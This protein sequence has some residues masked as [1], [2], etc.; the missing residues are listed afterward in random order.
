M[1]E[2]IIDV[3]HASNSNFLYLPTKFPLSLAYSACFREELYRCGSG[4]DFADPLGAETSKKGAAWM[5]KV[6][7]VTHSTTD[8]I[9]KSILLM[10][11][12]TC[13]FPWFLP[14]TLRTC[15]PSGIYFEMAFV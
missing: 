14:R 1:R 6:L 9:Q 5:I 3:M 13:E 2:Y 8:C 11:E 15:R 4:V 12:Q 10:R 7:H